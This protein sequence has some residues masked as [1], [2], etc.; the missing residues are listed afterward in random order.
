VQEAWIFTEHPDDIE[1]ADLR[2]PRTPWA[3]GRVD[4]TPAVEKNFS[5]DALIVGA[6]ITGAL[7][8]ERLTRQ[9]LQVVLIDRE[10]PGQGSTLASTA[11]LL[12]EIDRSLAELS[13]LHGFERAVRCYRASIHALNG[14]QALVHEH[15]LSCQ[16]RSRSSLYLTA[17][18]TPK[19]LQNEFSLRQKADLPG[20]FL[21]HAALL[22]QFEIT[23][24]G[25]ILSPNCADAD[26]VQLAKGIL[27]IARQRGAQLFNADATAFDSGSSRVT[28]G[29]SDGHEIEARH[30]VLATG[31]VPPKIVK[32]TVQ[33][34][35]SSWAIATDP[36]PRNIWKD[37]VL[38]WEDCEEYNYARTSVDGRII[39]GGEDSDEIVEPAS[40][41]EM[42][43]HKTARLTRKL[44]ALWPRAKLDL[45]FHWSGVFDTT[46]DGLPLIGPISGSRNLYAAFGY[47]G[48]GIT[49]SYLAAELIGN[50][51]AGGTSPLLK[52]FAVDR[53]IG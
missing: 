21:D 53:D 31:Y 52:D 24:A 46:A 23:R 39:F 3:G 28:V 40:R 2:S 4:R 42:D 17:S 15:A 36:Q 19:S 20:A 10:I 26:P 50:L 33:K 13:A 14:L 29:L 6:G 5:C 27:D 25:A 22:D 1:Q 16:M 11:M 12:W 37:G 18:D 34:V 41:D 7:L 43:T 48:N 51:I 38:I 47:G 30:V 32:S 45:A 8:A 35:T 49:F 44:A 9:G